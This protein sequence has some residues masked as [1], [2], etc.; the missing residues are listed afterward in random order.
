MVGEV[1]QI[2]YSNF[3]IEK[4]RCF[5]LKI[6]I[7]WYLLQDVNQM[8]LFCSLP[9]PTGESTITAGHVG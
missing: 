7:I 2:H 6:H 4:Q 1:Y 8:K 5:W 3:L 9:D